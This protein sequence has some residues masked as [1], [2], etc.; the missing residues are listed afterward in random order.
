[1]PAPSGLPIFSFSA[2]PNLPNPFQLP[3]EI[4]LVDLVN[5]ILGAKTAGED[6]GGESRNAE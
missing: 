1:M 4:N 6:A 3:V 2:I 5:G